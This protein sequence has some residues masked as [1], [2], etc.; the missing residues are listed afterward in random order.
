MFTYNISIKHTHQQGKTYNK[1]NYKIEFIRP[2]DIIRTNS[3]RSSTIAYKTLQ[4]RGDNTD[5]KRTLKQRGTNEKYNAVIY[6]DA[7]VWCTTCLQ[8]GSRTRA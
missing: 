7:V 3:I 6:N 8:H 5:G 1:P 2:L 4:N